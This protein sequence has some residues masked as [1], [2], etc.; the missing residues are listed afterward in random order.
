MKYLCRDITPHLMLIPKIIMRYL[1][2]DKETMVTNHKNSYI[3]HSEL[4]NSY[5]SFPSFVERLP[6]RDYNEE[7]K[8]FLLEDNISLGVCFKIT[9]ISCEARPAK[10]LEEIA[11]AI[12]D[13]LKN[14]IPCE[15]DTPWILQI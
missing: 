10:M 11:F 2:K 15:K 4:K 3:K 8:C 5:H 14:S 12:S 7:H 9:P 1:M 6:W 13:A